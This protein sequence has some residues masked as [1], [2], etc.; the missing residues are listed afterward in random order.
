MSKAFH[1]IK[2]AE[3]V[4]YIRGLQIAMVVVNKAKV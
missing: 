3:I 1:R 4:G 2:R